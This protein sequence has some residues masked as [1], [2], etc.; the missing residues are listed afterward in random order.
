M[1]NYF[2]L[3]SNFW[4]WFK[5]MM[6]YSIVASPVNSVKGSAFGSA[7]RLKTKQKVIL[8][9][10][11]LQKTGCRCYQIA[12]EKITPISRFFKAV[13]SFVLAFLSN[14]FPTFRKIIQGR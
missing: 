2:A 7:D 12:L 13:R 10:V 6:S 14:V 8:L 1:A 5:L 3:A 9:S 11:N 4:T